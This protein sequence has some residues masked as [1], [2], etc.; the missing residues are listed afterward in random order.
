[1]A[2]DVDWGKESDLHT[3]SVNGRYYQ[4][5]RLSIDYDVGER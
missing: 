2:V 3:G 4:I 1:M 5:L